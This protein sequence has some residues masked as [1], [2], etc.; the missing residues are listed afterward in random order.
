[1]HAISFNAFATL[2]DETGVINPNSRF[3][4]KKH[5]EGIFILVN[6]PEVCVSVSSTPGK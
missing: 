6:A 1:M 5:I 4:Q 2:F 3:C